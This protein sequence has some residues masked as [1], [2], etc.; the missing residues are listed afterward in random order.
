MTSVGFGTAVNVG[1]CVGGHFTTQGSSNQSKGVMQASS[2]VGGLSTLGAP[3][4]NPGGFNSVGLNL[5]GFNQGSG[6]T[7]SPNIAWTAQTRVWVI[8]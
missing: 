8:G 4:Y 7:V 6:I 3:A 2:N 1:G 5:N